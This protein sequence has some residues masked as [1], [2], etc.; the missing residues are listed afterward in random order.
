MK[1]KEKM[2]TINL[3]SV[4]DYL[5]VLFENTIPSKQ[6][7]LNAKKEYW[8]AYNTDLKRRF[9][10]KHTI[11]QISFTKQEMLCIQAK[12]VEGESATK[13]IYNLVLH[14]LQEHKD[15]GRKTNTA[16]IEQQLFL[17][18]EYLNELLEIENA[19]VE[20]IQELE[21]HIKTLEQTIE[22]VL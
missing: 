2:K 3:T 14:H 13:Y 1:K 8:R 19:D 11:L 12:L 6:D 15:F 5:D 22:D 7:V 4:H 18:V 9:R 10:K 17:I 20:K 16:L 21:K